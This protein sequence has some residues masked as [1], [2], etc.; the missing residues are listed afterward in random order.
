MM[1]TIRAGVGTGGLYTICYPFDRVS[2]SVSLSCSD[3]LLILKSDLISKPT[4][5]EPQISPIF[6]GEM[7][8][9]PISFSLSL[10]PALSRLITW[11][12]STVI[13]HP[14]P[15]ILVCSV[16]PATISHL[17]N[18]ALVQN[19]EITLHTHE[20]GWNQKVR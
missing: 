20:E 11:E 5:L 12:Y 6:I 15:S 10:G 17:Q 8:H 2:A 4:S 9:F 13:V 19:H 7:T 16:L 1:S 3:S 14:P 18:W